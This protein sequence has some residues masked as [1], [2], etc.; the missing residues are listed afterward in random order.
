MMPAYKELGKEIPLNIRFAEKPDMETWDRYVK[1][2]PCGTLFHLSA[3][4]TVIEK[5]FRHNSFYLIAENTAGI[6]GILPLF[7]IKSRLFGHFFISVPFAEIGGALA[8]TPETEQ[9]LIDKAS[10]LTR[11]QNA[12][13]L[14][15][16]NRTPAEGLETKSLYYNF[17]KEISSDHDEN[18][19]AIPRK[20]RAMVRNASKNGLASE[21]GHHILNEFYTILALNYHRLGTPIFPKKFF[22]NFLDAYKENADILVVRTPDGDLASAV[23]FFTF[24]EQMVPY[25]A[26]SDFLFRH[27]GPNDFMYWELMKHAVD[28]GLTIFDYGRSKQGT[29]SFSFKKH[30][31]FTPEPLAYQYDL[32]GI[33][34]LPN[35]SPA[36]PRYQKKIEMWRKMPHFL[37]K[38]LGPIIA[39]N[40]A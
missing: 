35:L 24:K 27:L 5:T 38:F 17:R 15:L 34:E 13:Y 32:A 10:Q 22:T 16:R 4:K 18:L 11:R 30:W 25:Y 2:H 33:K 19:K 31:G 12:Q 1:D 28:K 29:G 7:E 39:R 9:A 23:L 6:C 8:D 26:G 37:T 36:N 21:T 14:E 3:W 20:S 40:L